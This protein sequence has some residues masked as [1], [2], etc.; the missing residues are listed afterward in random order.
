MKHIRAV[1]IA[2]CLLSAGGCASFPLPGSGTQE[3]STQAR[4]LLVDDLVHVLAQL[5]E[6]RR[7]TIQFNET[8]RADYGFIFD[9]LDQRGYGLQRVSADQGAN[10]LQ[11]SRTQ[12]G[13]NSKRTTEVEIA[14][15]ALAVGRRYTGL[16]HGEA[17]AVSA[18]WIKGSALPVAPNLKVLDGNLQ[19]NGDVLVV[20]YR[21]V[22]NFNLPRISDVDGDVAGTLADGDLPTDEAINAYDQPIKNV[23]FTNESNFGNLTEGYETVSRDVIVFGNDSLILGQQGKKSVRR[24]WRDFNIQTDIINLLGCSNGYTD[25]EIGNEGL[26]LGRS[27]RVLEEFESL[28]VPRN[29][30][31]DEG[32]WAPDPVSGRYPSRGV[33]VELKRRTS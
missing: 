15:G 13:Q 20:E 28:G 22:L 16:Y 23:W 24:I 33:V 7:T 17:R 6:P 8:I 25:L 4:Q 12:S 26:A 18:L 31:L 10:F 32:C 9:E 30:L 1:S 21:D 19:A 29:Q 2:V 14:V 27:R 5:L 3:L 11:I